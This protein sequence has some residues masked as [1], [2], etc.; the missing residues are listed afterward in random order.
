MLAQL[1]TLRGCGPL[2]LDWVSGIDESQSQLKQSDVA[3]TASSRPWCVCVCGGGGGAGCR[4]HRLEQALVGGGGGGGDEKQWGRPDGGVIEREVGL[5]HSSG[6]HSYGKH[7]SHLL[8][9]DRCI[10]ATMDL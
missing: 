9:S 1:A 10:Q 4:S 8:C 6:E 7:S 3:A 5:W 2:V